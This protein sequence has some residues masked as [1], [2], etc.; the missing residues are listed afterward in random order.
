MHPGKKNVFGKQQHV[1]GEGC[2]K[3][4]FQ[5]WFI[6]HQ[7]ILKIDKYKRFPQQMVDFMADDFAAECYSHE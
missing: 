3:K 2:K 7:E 5:G 1:Y 6:Y 4:K